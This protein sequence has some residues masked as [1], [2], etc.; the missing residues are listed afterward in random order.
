L[1]RPKKAKTF[2]FALAIGLT[3]ASARAAE[4]AEPA[5]STTLEFA[6]GLY[7]RKMYGPAIDEYAKFIESSPASPELASARFRYAD[8]FY[9]TKNYKS[10][11]S[12]FEGFLK[13][14]P[15]DKRAVLARFRIGTS[16]YKL[17]QADAAAATFVQVSKEAKDPSLRSASLFYLA[18]SHEAAG[19]PEKT[20]ALYQQLIK[21]YPQSEYASYAAV[22]LGDALLA[23]KEYRPAFEA[24]R[25]AGEKSAPAEIARQARFRAAEILFE[26]GEFKEAR[27]WYEKLAFDAPP[28]R[29]E[30]R[31]TAM[32]LRAKAVLG[33]FH[34]DYRLNDADS[35]RARLSGKAA[36]IARTP[37]EP[38]ILF[39][40]GSLEESAKRGEEAIELFD[41]TA[42]HPGADDDLRARATVRKSEIFA[43]S[44][45]KDAALVEV[46]K[47]FGKG[48]AAE[49]R[50]YYEKG[51]LFDAMGR[52][53]EALAS[54]TAVMER[55]PDTDFAKAALYQSAL[56][57]RKLAQ[58]AEA[59][60]AFERYAN[61]YPDDE[62]AENA[63]LE[64]MQIDLDSKDF[65]R[66]AAIAADF[67]GTRPSSKYRDAALYKRGI[68][69]TGLKRFPDAAVQ[70][71]KTLAVAET[72]LRA[73]ALFGAAA[74][75]DAAEDSQ[76]AIPLYEELAQKHEGHPLANEALSHLG[77]L[78]FKM[79][80]HADAAALYERILEFMPDV[81]IRAEE[82][83]WLIQYEIDRAQYATIQKLIPSLPQRFPE[84]DFGH[85][86]NFFLGESFMGQKEYPRAIAHYSEAL[87]VK[88]EG[89]YAPHSHL[90]MGI[91]SAAQGE[92][93]AA[94]KFFRE[95]LRYDFEVKIVMRARFE[96]AN[97]R[98]A[99]ADYAEAA[100]AF[101]LVA[102]LYEDPKYVPLSLFKAGECFSRLQRAE[103]AE[104]AF[105]ELE[106]R[107]P[108]H[109]LLKKAERLRQRS[110][111]RV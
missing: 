12:Y 37:Y 77:Y 84:R 58:P 100:K 106:S 17:G 59:R 54:Y 74:A 26:I 64:V 98:L 8:S 27:V 108:R 63:L 81:K 101:M 102:I 34:C 71:E 97:L 85:E 23:R 21:G 83:F 75:Y 38:E 105:T 14:H 65:E 70:F 32:E 66:A 53:A 86:I 11:I 6:N 25:F 57:R 82:V 43:K 69:L 62:N 48:T 104:N 103:E 73:E 55:H 20:A 45:R 42:T 91:A 49:S 76:K 15:A 96:I 89:L 2:L 80:R 93:D 109:P 50:A 111:A 88:P 33:L 67:V 10:A 41:R 44:D 36:E 5:G 87:Q 90:G 35:A 22:A 51:N 24:Y 79:E 99:A 31:R 18:K 1:R 72:K 110:A 78:Y 4:S 60:A 3:T 52:H 46:E 28:E 7:A 47:L 39:I 94:E 68:A 13:N 29:E 61:K 107:Y 19:R 40:V 95:T 30:N 16:Q 9:F 92:R 56:V